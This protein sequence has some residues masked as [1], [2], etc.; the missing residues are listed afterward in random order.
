MAIS[1]E[2]RG[3]VN[4]AD[5]GGRDKA[6]PFWFAPERRDHERRGVRSRTTANRVRVVP[7]SE[8]Y[9][10]RETYEVCSLYYE[11]EKP[12]HFSDPHSR[13]GVHPVWLNGDFSE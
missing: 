2:K 9:D 12:Y 4:E 5:K 3:L 1:G 13:Y 7:D 11:A 8:Q 10:E 6:L